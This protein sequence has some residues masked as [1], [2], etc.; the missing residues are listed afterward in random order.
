MKKRVREHLLVPQR[1]T[2]AEQTRKNILSKLV[3]GVGQYSWM[4][5]LNAFLTNVA[6]AVQG[7][8]HPKKVISK[9]T[10]LIFLNF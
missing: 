3:V 4:F 6:L 7:A 2:F 5:K 9:Q 1:Q 10:F 8:M